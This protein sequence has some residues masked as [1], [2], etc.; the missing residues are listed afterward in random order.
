LIKGPWWD[1]IFNELPKVIEELIH[2]YET[3][4]LKHHPPKVENKLESDKMIL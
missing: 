4:W 2:P 1:Y 3:M